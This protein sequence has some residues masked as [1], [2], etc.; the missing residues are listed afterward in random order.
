VAPPLMWKPEWASG[1]APAMELLCL[2]IVG[3]M[4]R[5]KWAA[6]SMVRKSIVQACPTVVIVPEPT[7]PDCLDRYPDLQC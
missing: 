4:G 2:C 6:Q 1:A 3:Q 7:W 5:A